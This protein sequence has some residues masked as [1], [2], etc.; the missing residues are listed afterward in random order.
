MKAWKTFRK[1]HKGA[2]GNLSHV[3]IQNWKNGGIILKFYT[4]TAHPLGLEV[5][6]DATE[7][8]ELQQAIER[9]RTKSI[10]DSFS[11]NTQFSHATSKE[12]E[13]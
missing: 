5:H 6:F 2:S 1:S 7:I 8:E 12:G 13:K 11:S 10:T 3:C 9:C 4:K